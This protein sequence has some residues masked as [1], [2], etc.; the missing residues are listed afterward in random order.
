MSKLAAFKA[1]VPA[2]S[3]RVPRSAAAGPSEGHERPSETDGATSALRDI[4][5]LLADNNES[6]AP[7]TPPVEECS[8]APEGHHPVAGAGSGSATPAANKLAQFTSTVG[9]GEGKDSTAH[10]PVTKR[11]SRL[12]EFLVSG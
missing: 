10:P 8:T 3:G 9:G 5:S 7:S 12:A 4:S 1:S 6:L 2:A 11:P